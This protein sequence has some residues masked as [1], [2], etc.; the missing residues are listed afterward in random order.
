MKQRRQSEEKY[1]LACEFIHESPGA[2]LITDFATG[3]RIWIPLSQV[4]KMT[5]RP[6]D[7]KG[8][9]MGAIVMSAWVAKKKG[10]I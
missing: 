6:P 9:V 8:R 2:V 10:L 1:E 5:K 3:E 4:H 7:D